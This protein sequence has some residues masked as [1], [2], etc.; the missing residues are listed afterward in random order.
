MEDK[1]DEV[2]RRDEEGHRAL[3]YDPSQQIRVIRV[4][5]I[6]GSESADPSHDRYRRDEEGHRAL[7]I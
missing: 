5:R 1:A 7:T 4:I 6:S 2:E 3:V